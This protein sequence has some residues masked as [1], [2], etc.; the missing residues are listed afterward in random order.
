MGNDG[1][2]SVVELQCENESPNFFSGVFGPSCEN[3]EL[4]ATHPNVYQR[5]HKA[6]HINGAAWYEGEDGKLAIWRDILGS[7]W[8]IGDIT[9]LGTWGHSLLWKVGYNKGKIICAHDL[10][11][12]WDYHPIHSVDDK[13]L[14]ISD[15]PAEI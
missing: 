13:Q 11:G 14:Q 3:S 1:C 8:S 15:Y 4:K 9:H 12:G 5:Y 7:I 10:P 6:G 2:K